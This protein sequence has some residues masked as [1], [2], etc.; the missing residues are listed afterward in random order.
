M[1]VMYTEKTPLPEL[2]PVEL[3]IRLAETVAAARSWLEGISGARASVAPAEG[4]WSAKEVMGHL[5][6]SAVNN[7]Q[8]M[9]RLE[10]GPELRSQNYEQKE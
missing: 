8:R 7:L 4:K 3:G 6:D 5:I 9:V 1:A 10:I 2:D